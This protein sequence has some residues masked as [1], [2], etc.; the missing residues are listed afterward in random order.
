MLYRQTRTV[1]TSLVAVVLGLVL[2]NNQSVE[3][4]INPSDCTGKIK[5]VYVRGSGQEYGN[6]S[7][8]K[9][10]INE[11]GKYPEINKRLEFVELSS[12]IPELAGLAEY[13][14]T[15]VAGNWED[16]KNGV[17][18]VITKASYGDYAQSLDTGIEQ[19]TL[20]LRLYRDSNSCSIL[21]GYSQGAHV[22]GDT[23]QE[24]DKTYLE[25]ILYIGLLGDP[26]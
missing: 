17:G 20:L 23:L 16:I 5:V 7:E 9:R 24:V 21:V 25:N 13:R 1:I 18:A 11:L 4:A 19:L 2:F 12:R 10:L 26:M 6:S 3:A 14:A 15:A 8:Q 22:I